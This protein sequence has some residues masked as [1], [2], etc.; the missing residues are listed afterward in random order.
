MRGS[1]VGLTAKNKILFSGGGSLDSFSSADGPYVSTNR[2]AGGK[3]VSNYKLAD[4]IHVDT[5]HIYGS[6]AGG[7]R[8]AGYVPQWLGRGVCP[9]PHP[10]RGHSGALK[11]FDG[12]GVCL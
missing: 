1:G 3:A 5:A 6:A 9:G 11:S 2:H 10:I 7:P 8:G 12:A 4:G